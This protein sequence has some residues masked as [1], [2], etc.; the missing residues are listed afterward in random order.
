MSSRYREGPKK[1]MNSSLSHGS[2]V[3]EPHRD[4]VASLLRRAHESINCHQVFV[5]GLVFG[6]ITSVLLLF[7]GRDAMG[8]LFA[9]ATAFLLFLFFKEICGIGN[10]HW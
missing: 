3:N 4:R 7:S 10:Q 5:E 9:G 6:F 2:P 1:E 8:I